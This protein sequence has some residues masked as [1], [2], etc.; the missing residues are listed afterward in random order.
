VANVLRAFDQVF[1]EPSQF[2][3]LGLGGDG[4]LSLGDLPLAGH[5]GAPTGRPERADP[6]FVISAKT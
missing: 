5:T 4:V 6:R 2:D 1:E 3:P